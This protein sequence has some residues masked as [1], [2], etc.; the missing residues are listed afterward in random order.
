MKKIQFFTMIALAGS[1]LL[2][3]SCSK[4][5]PAGPSGPSGPAGPSLTGN[6]KGH[7]FQYDQYGSPI[8]T[9]LAGIRDSLSPTNIAVTDTSG[10]YK[11]SN[12]TTGDYTFSVSK[13]G[14]GTVLAQAVQIVGGGDLY[15]DMRI[16]QIPNFAVL[17]PTAVLNTT[18]GNI[19]IT[20]NVAAMDTRTREVLIFVGS[21]AA[22]SSN[23][24][25]YLNVY[26]RT[27]TATKTSGVVSLSPSDIH[28][29]G[30]NAGGTLYVS[31]SAATITFN[32][33]SFYQD[34]STGKTVYTAL[35]S[36]PMTCSVIAP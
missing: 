29:L 10:L 7:V 32:S 13:T 36:G 1:V 24:A 23:P 26:P 15:R 14:Y 21:S 31:V 2:I 28:D 11:F 12:L 17:A 22:T 18:T 30:I 35:G 25:T 5:G 16:A 34:L 27:I 19:D 20:A 9:G 4:T 8:L 3:S 6:L 33:A